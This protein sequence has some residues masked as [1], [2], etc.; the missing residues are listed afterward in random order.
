MMT[1]KVLVLYNAPD[2]PSAFDAYYRDHHLALVR[3]VPGLR[4]A[5]SSTGPVGT[6]GGPSDVYQVSTYTFDSMA[7][8]QEGLASAAGVAAADDLANFAPRG[9][10]L[11]LFEDDEV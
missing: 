5:S 3:A 9:V 2:D 8:L 11:L 6:P 10:T 4:S 7:A 1:A